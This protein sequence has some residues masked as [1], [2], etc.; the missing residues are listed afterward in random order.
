MHYEIIPTERASQDRWRATTRG[1]RYRISRSDTDL[2][3]MHWHPVGHSPFKQPHLHIPELLGGLRGE[4]GH[5]PVSRVTFEDAVE[6]VITMSGQH[7]RSDWR[8]VLDRTRQK[9]LDHRSWS[10]TPPQLTP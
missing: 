3:L 9:H 6:W 10:H 7:A 2:V 8:S 5:L 1:Y 4:K